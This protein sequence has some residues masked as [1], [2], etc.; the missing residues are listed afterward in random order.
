MSEPLKTKAYVEANPDDFKESYARAR[1]HFSKFPGI[2]GVAFG[3]KRTG[4][5]YEDNIAIVIFVIEKKDE[6]EL[7]PDQVIPPSFEGYPTDVRV[8]RKGIAEGCD[9]TTKYDKIKGG[10]QIMVET[11]NGH[12]QG[13]LGCL[14]K[15]RGN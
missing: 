3:Q 14:V 1:E 7:P 10:I 9:N 6:A 5:V 13:T 2:V 8:V 4:L 11:E 12:A 15:K